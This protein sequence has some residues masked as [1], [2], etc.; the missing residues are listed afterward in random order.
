MPRR[1]STDEVAAALERIGIRFLRQR[2]SHLRY[3]GLWRTQQRNVT[4]VAGQRLI[5]PRTLAF[6]LKQAGLTAEEFARI[7]EGESISK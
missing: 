2:G 3:Q 7:V 4:L 5:P 1:Y 6:I